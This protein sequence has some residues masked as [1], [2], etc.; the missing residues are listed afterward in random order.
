MSGVSSGSLLS[1][2]SGVIG[3]ASFVGRVGVGVVV[4]FQMAM[5]EVLYWGAHQ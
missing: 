4:L 5:T 3:V 2:G 1:A